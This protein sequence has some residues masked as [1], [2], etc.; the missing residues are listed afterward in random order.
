ME[1]WL[2]PWTRTMAIAFWQCHNVFLWE[3]KAGHDITFLISLHLLQISPFCSTFCRRWHLSRCQQLGKMISA[4]TTFEV[5]M[6]LIQP[7]ET[8]KWCKTA[9][10]RVNREYL[11][12]QNAR[13]QKVDLDNLTFFFNCCVLVFQVMLQR[14]SLY[15]HAFTW[16]FVSIRFGLAKPSFL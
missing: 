7:S 14:C 13:V 16:V 11:E 9:H 12:A 3:R 15:G 4:C 10:F 8:H 2:W 1:Q 5:L 6:H